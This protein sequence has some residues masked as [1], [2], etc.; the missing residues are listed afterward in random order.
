MATFEFKDK[1]FYIDGRLKLQ[2]DKKIIPDLKKKDKDVVFIVD[3]AERSGKSV[4]AMIL[5]AYVASILKT[6][7]NLSNVCMNPDEFRRKI[8]GAEKNQVV[9]YDEAHRGMASS[10]ALSEINKILKD[11]MMEMGQ[12]NL[13]VMVIL[14]TFFLLDKYAALFRAIG[15]F[16]I[17]E[18]RRRRGFWVYY[19]KNNKIRL[20]MKGKREFN[21]NCIKYP[22][23][24]GRFYNQYGVEEEEYRIKK[25]DSFKNKPIPA[26]EERF[27]GQRDRLIWVLHKELGLSSLKLTKVMK[28][29]GLGLAGTAI[30]DILRKIR[31]KEGKSA[32]DTN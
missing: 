7:F 27:K 1:T 29:Y 10:R 12:K 8:E 15:L 24:R 26:K 20:Y 6:E 32:V 13:F 16:H 17:Y 14:P 19:N 11:L 25:R 28:F 30:R 4:F 23:F 2:L 3:G 5:G 18:N 22:Y 9:I 21:Y 31:E